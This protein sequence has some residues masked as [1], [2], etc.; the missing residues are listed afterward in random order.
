MTPEYSYLVI[1]AG[2]AG[3]AAARALADAG[4]TVL[5]LERRAQAS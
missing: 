4:E 1:G 2:M 3:A 5:I